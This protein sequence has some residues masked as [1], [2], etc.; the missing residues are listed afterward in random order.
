MGAH[1]GIVAIG[2]FFAFIL[3]FIIGVSIA[4]FTVF[5]ISVIV[6]EAGIV[7]CSADTSIELWPVLF[8]DPRLGECHRWGLGTIMNGVSS[9]LVGFMSLLHSWLC[10]WHCLNVVR[11]KFCVLTHYWCLQVQNAH[12]SMRGR[13]LLMWVVPGL[14]V[15]C[16]CHLRAEEGKYAV[17]A[18]ALVH[19]WVKGGCH[20]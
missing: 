7:I 12:V 9:M 19:C 1:V 18:V 20:W 2:V 13:C 5:I 17:I 3:V 4:R 6:N 15:G 10:C 14:C 11:A 8:L 16:C